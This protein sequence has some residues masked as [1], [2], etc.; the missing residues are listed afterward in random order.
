MRHHPITPDEIAD[1]ETAHLDRFA[2]DLLKYQLGCAKQA[3]IRKQPG[4]RARSADGAEKARA[5]HQVV[6]AELQ[7]RG[8]RP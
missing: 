1:M 3:R 2:S 6:F 5:A 8:A 4:M 7:R